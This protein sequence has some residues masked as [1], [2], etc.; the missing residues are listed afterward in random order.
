LAANKSEIL[1]YR[2]DFCDW[3]IST[4]VHLSGVRRK[5]SWGRVHTVAYGVICI[6]CELFVTSYLCF[7]NLRFGEVCADQP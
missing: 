4:E 5:F 2:R 7:P 6:W 3:P 1:D